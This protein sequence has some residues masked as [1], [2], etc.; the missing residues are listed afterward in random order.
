MN[1]LETTDIAFA[2]TLILMGYPLKKITVTGRLGKF[3]FSHQARNEENAYDLGELM[4]DPRKFHL[5]LKH[6][7]TLVKKNTNG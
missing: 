7:T 4:V 2:S 1:D 3:V 5:E 6:L